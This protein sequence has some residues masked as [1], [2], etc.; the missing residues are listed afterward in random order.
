M[1]AARVPS[2]RI[3]S[4]LHSSIVA[5]DW[6]IHQSRRD[7]TNINSFCLYFRFFWSGGTGLG[8]LFQMHDLYRFEGIIGHHRGDFLG[9]DMTAIRLATGGRSYFTSAR[10]RDK[11]WVSMLQSG[12]AT[13]R[14]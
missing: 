2:R 7:F 9:Y 12:S 14:F 13:G 6:H 3:R 11:D 5:I 8:G 4:V 10:R 1:L